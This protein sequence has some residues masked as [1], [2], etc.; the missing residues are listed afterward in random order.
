MIQCIRY[1]VLLKKN[2]SFK[3]YFFPLIFNK[4]KYPIYYTFTCVFLI[5]N[6]TEKKIRK[7]VP[8]NKKIRIWPEPLC[9]SFIL[10]FFLSHKV[11]LSG[12]EPHQI[13]FFLN[14]YQKFS[15][16]W[17]ISKSKLI[18]LYLIVSYQVQPKELFLNY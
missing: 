3:I 1:T 13:Y 7:N 5:F 4:K 17:L 15:S 9:K 8:F 6:S 10:L 16:N 2:N 12:D 14:L 18:G 11:C